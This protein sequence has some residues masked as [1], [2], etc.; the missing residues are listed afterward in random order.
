MTSYLVIKTPLVQ[1]V[2]AMSE[3]ETT[4]ASNWK[5]ISDSEVGRLVV[6]WEKVAFTFG[7]N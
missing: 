1:R 7:F 2:S 4:S 5:V 3:S 6:H